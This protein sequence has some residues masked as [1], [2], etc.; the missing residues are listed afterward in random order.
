MKVNLLIP[1]YIKTI[2]TIVRARAALDL[3]YNDKGF[4]RYCGITVFEK[5]LCQYL[6]C[7]ACKIQLYALVIWRFCNLLL[8][9]G[10]FSS[11]IQPS[12]YW[13]C[14]LVLNQV[15]PRF[16]IALY[17]EPYVQEVLSKRPVTCHNINRKVFLQ[18]LLVHGVMLLFDHW[19]IV[20][21]YQYLDRSSKPH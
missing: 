17:N 15:L 3:K 18:F 21:K 16:S 7:F 2:K 12:M 10:E 14:D 20:P 9:R 1:N 6:I 4:I 13:H 8:R 5:R 19:H 11:D